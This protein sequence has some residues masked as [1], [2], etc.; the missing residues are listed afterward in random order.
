MQANLI[1]L[2]NQQNGYG[3]RV[4]QTTIT[5][6]TTS[7]DGWATTGNQTPVNATVESHRVQLNDWLR[8]GAPMSGGLAVAVGTSGALLA[9]DTGHPLYG[10]WEITDNVESA[11]NSGIWKAGYTTDGLHPNIT[12]INAASI[13]VNTAIIT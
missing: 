1:M 4:I 3:Q 10:Y 2:W 12:G 7:T 13:G 9:G 6:N 11:R 8:G 5:P